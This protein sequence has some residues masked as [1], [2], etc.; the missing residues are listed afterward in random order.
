MEARPDLPETISID[1]QARAA[2]RRGQEIRPADDRDDIDAL[3]E[4]CFAFINGQGQSEALAY[5]KT[6]ADEMIFW[7]RRHRERAHAKS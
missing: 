4:Q 1:E 7:L 6:K 5:A 3:R 2:G